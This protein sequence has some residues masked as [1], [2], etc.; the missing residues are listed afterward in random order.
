VGYHP[1]GETR[2]AD[3]ADADGTGVLPRAP[4]IDGQG[5]SSVD[6]HSAGGDEV[7]LRRGLTR[8]GDSSGMFRHCR[9]RGELERPAEPMVLPARFPEPA[10]QRLR[11]IAVGRYGDEDTGRTTR[12]GRGRG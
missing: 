5:T 1:H 3:Y 10:R 6:L 2:F 4:L 8:M 12:R 11:W 9:L 7:Q